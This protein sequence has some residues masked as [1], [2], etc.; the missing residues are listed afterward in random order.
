M[1]Q[2]LSEPFNAVLKIIRPAQGNYL[3]KIKLNAKD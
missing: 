2:I 1:A 3:E